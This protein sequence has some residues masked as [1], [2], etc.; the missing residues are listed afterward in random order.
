MGGLAAPAAFVLDPLNITGAQDAVAPRRQGPSSA[1]GA[2]VGQATAAAMGPAQASGTPQQPGGFKGFIESLGGLDGWSG[3]PFWRGDLKTA[4]P[5][6]PPQWIYEQG[7]GATW[8][9]PER[10]GAT[11]DFTFKGNAPGTP[12]YNSNKGN[13]F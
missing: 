5:P 6:P 2:G 11:N 12:G 13:R 10:V 8:G 7:K 1:D 9:T 4:A 3:K